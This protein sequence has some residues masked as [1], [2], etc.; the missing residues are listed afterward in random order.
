ML[1]INPIPLGKDPWNYGIA[2]DYHTISS[3]KDLDGSFVTD[4]TEIGEC[5][6][7]LK[8]CS[9]T[10][11]AETIA[12]TAARWL[13]ENLRVINYI[14]YIVPIPPTQVR[15]IQPVRLVA[16]RISKL[17]DIPVSF[18]L[19]KIKGTQNIKEV[20]DYNERIKELN[21]AFDL[22]NPAAYFGKSILLVDDVYRSGVTLKV[23]TD[24][25]KNKGKVRAVYALAITKTRVKR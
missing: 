1:K 19:I 25:L 7:R 5:L 18:N 17:L 2:L 11:E 10:K 22:K 20:E 8:Y 15:A 9:E 24:L 14:N 3:H 6:Y 21:G 4:R 16:E 12:Q 13:K 23:I